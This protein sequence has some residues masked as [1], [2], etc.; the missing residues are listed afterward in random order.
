MTSL[1]LIEEALHLPRA[2]RA[3]LASKLLE[4][5]DEDDHEM[6]D[7]WLVEIRRRVQEMK[8]GTAKMIPHEEVMSNVRAR[9]AKKREARA[10]QAS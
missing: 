6:S 9:L 10:A 1:E 7:E 2:D 5:L 8:S 3:H 4:S